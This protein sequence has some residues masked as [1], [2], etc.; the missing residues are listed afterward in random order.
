MEITAKEVEVIK[1]FIQDWSK[2]KKYELETTFGIGGVVDATTFLQI[3][4]RLRNKGFAVSPQQDDRISI[5]TPSHIRLTLQGLG[6]L[7]SYCKDDTLQG[8]VFSAMFKDRAFPESN[9]DLQEYNIRFKVRRE[10]EL[11]NDDPRIE[12]LLTNWEKQDKAFRLIRRWSFEGNGIRVDMS[13]VRQSPYDPI[14][15][16]FKWSKRFLEHNIF[17][18]LP[19]YEVEVELLHNTPYTDTPEKALQAIIAGVG[20]VQRGIQKNT[21]LIRNSVSNSI[22]SE[23]A[24]MIGAER[25]RGVNPVT[26]EV[27]NM[28]FN[29]E[30][31]IPN[32]CNGFNVTDKADGLRTM[33]FVDKSGELYLI[34]MSM[35]IYRTGLKN[36][37]CASSLVD[38][39]W[40]TTKKNGEATNVYL[41]FD[42]YFFTDKKDTTN[43]PFIIIK[44]NLLDKDAD[45]R[46]NL[47]NE[48][49]DTW[50]S[51]EKIIAKGVTVSTKLDIYLKRFEFATPDS[52][53]IFRACAKV[54]DISRDYHTDGLILTSNSEPIPQKSGSRWDY[55]FKW[56]PAKDN[57][58]DFLIYYEK[59][60]E[61]PSLDKITTAIH[62]TNDQNIQFKT[63]KLFVGSDKSSIFENPRD[64]ILSERPIIKDKVGPS[65][66]QPVLF[67][68]IDYPDTMANIC[69]IPLQVIDPLSNE[70]YCMTEDSQEPIPDRSI[71]EMRYDPNREHGWRWVP[72][73]IRHDK[74]ERLLRAV[75]KKGTINYS[76][77]MN[78]EKTANSVW[79]SI[80][81]PITLSMIRTGKEEPEEHEMKQE[82][83]ET[84][85]T[86]KYYEQKASKTDLLLV[87]GLQKFHNQYIKNEILLRSSLHGG[88]KKLLDLSC[89]KGGDLY[90][91]IF[92]HAESVMG[93][94]IAADNITNSY[95]GAYKRYLDA[96][97]DLGPQRVPPMAFAIGN[98]SKRI[99]DGEAG[100]TPEERDILRS[101][102]GKY[103]PEGPIPKYIENK[104]AGKFR[105]G[106]DV[107]ACMFALHYFFE[108]KTVLDGFLQNL[109]DTVKVGG[110]FI[111][112]C[113]DG[114]KIFNL[115]RNVSKGSSKSGKEGDTPIW[116]ITKD[117]NNDELTSDDDSIGLG[118][119]VE[120]IS[121]GTTHKE[122]LVPFDLLTKKLNEIGF[123]LLNLDELRDL[124]LRNSTNLFEDSYKMAEKS[125]KHYTMI[126]PVKEFSFLNRWFIFKRQ[127]QEELPTRFGKDITKENKNY[128]K[129]NIVESS[130]YSVLKPW[131]KEQVRT[132]LTSWLQP[133]SIKTIV[134]ATAHI[135]V[136][137]I[138]L[139]NIF[140]SAIID[141]FEIVPETF[142]KLRKNIITFKKQDFIRPHL[143]DVTQWEPTYTIDLLYADPPWGGLNYYKEDKIDLYLQKE[144]NEHNETKNINT[145]VDKW[146]DSGKIKNIV[147]KVPNNF[148]KE[149]LTSKYATQ[150]KSVINRAGNVAFYLIWIQ[151][152]LKEQE[153]IEPVEEEKEEL[154]EEEEIPKIEIES[155]LPGPDKEF[156]LNEV[157]KFGI[158][159][160][161]PPVDVSVKNDKG[162]E[163]IHIARYLSLAAP[164][165]IP[166]PDNSAVTYPSIEHYLAGMKLKY[167]SNKPDLAERLMSTEG[168]IHQSYNSKRMQ[169][170]I[171]PNTTRDFELLEKEA[172]DVRKKMTKTE[173]Q[174]YSVVTDDDKW[175]LMKD[176]VLMDALRY[177][178]MHD[179]RFHNI[180]EAAK[181][182]GKYL[183]YSTNI[184]S[185]ALELGGVR[186]AKTK[187]IEGDNKVGRFI[188]EL[189]EFQ[190]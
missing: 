104:M 86:K 116:T 79:N 162:K 154:K 103:D 14:I 136:D 163:D 139:S 25:F 70:Q 174:S 127:G 40:V 71:V 34:D 26:L 171:K 165:P 125:G 5:I 87:S 119:D 91:W 140:P 10:E 111:G 23:Y 172:I 164:F 74:T 151:S 106:T 57:T 67:N 37:K 29:P 168:D 170:K 54:L 126:K 147:L 135:G 58:V 185:V 31:T 188:M 180:V 42:I 145:L 157:F 96:L 21:L 184:Q 45:C 50:K 146:I 89:G 63:M 109:S 99:I 68:P 179:K 61:I 73:R 88:N 7:Q 187:K 11:S 98:S 123:S 36:P 6:V 132:I 60:P 64:T 107:A 38:G 128:E 15:G 75:S 33:G 4:Q 97:I 80:H 13:M 134:D 19:R 120:F 130:T 41:I 114:E 113:F 59:N 8:K 137:T 20:E 55:Q 129:F 100:A 155:K 182:S 117:Y 143:E 141:A 149:Y 46:Y 39:E 49:F 186:S 93:I 82:E 142:E 112:C 189:A 102:F 56:K 133:S 44:D 69:Y 65:K 22:R 16:G 124:G 131:H 181:N 28:I 72:S 173:L 160:D 153:R 3:S 30:K 78:D 9:I 166:D 47:M 167:A 1:K 77:T 177:R 94:D 81:N 51:D 92:N 122:Y 32:I 53:T 85:I 118:I 90:K 101:V 83:R 52:E 95:N 108:N 169:L 190:F 150:E 144:S 121:I 66:Y 27:Q 159:V 24:S 84:D 152:I 115:L 48:W 178:W 183:L 156:T 62:P 35:K 175:L 176:K 2:D 110:Y 18:E 43:K 76:G 12:A 138:H 105:S 158:G 17:R 161:K 148:D